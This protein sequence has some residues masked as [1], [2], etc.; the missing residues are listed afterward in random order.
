[1]TT[2]FSKI[3]TQVQE[4]HDK[5]QLDY[6]H[7]NDPF[8]NVRASEDFGIKSWVGCMVRAN[9]KMH[10]IQKAAQGGTMANE[11]VEDSLLDL[12]V[13]SIIALV[14]Y[15]EEQSG[16]KLQGGDVAVDI[17]ED[18]YFTTG[19]GCAGPYE[20]R[21]NTPEEWADIPGRGSLLGFLEPGYNFERPETVRGEPIEYFRNGETIKNRRALRGRR[22]GDDRVG[23][24]ALFLEQRDTIPGET[25]EAFSDDGGAGLEEQYAVRF[26]TRASEIAA[27]IQRGI[28]A[29][30]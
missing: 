2:E 26:P 21:V 3:L 13:Y 10:R 9:D 20:K 23:E 1:V 30:N 25:T 22:D 28:R 17:G 29:R 14:L 15:R 7:D 11:S 5:K 6:G 24:D 12:A 8:A 4:M 27:A 18:S 19:A 16:T